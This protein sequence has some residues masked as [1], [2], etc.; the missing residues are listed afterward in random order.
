M[1]LRDEN[2]FDADALDSERLMEMIPALEVRFGFMFGPH[3]FQDRRF[4][5]IAGV[6]EIV[7][8]RVQ[9]LSISRE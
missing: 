2:F 5:S 3:D 9:A 6:A 7:H 4:V 8:E 1:P